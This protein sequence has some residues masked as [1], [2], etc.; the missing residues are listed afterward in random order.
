MAFE[1]EPDLLDEEAIGHG[2]VGA[3]GVEPE[4]PD[5][6]LEPVAREHRK[7]AAQ[8]KRIKDGTLGD[9]KT[10]SAQFGSEKPRIECGVVREKRGAGGVT[11]KRQES[12][13]DLASGGRLGQKVIG[14]SM[15]GEGARWDRALW[16]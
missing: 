1:T 10:R 2:A 6:G 15:N 4:V 9:G 14:Q 8:R 16:D 12:R 11:E 5:N 3:T 7:P 13:Q